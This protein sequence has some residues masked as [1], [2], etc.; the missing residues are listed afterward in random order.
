MELNT[1]N[2]FIIDTETTGMSSVYNRIIEIAILRVENGRVVE[3]YHTLLN[4]QRSLPRFIEGITGITSE[5]LENAPEFNDI[6][7]K[8]REL[9]NDAIFV[10]HNSAFDYGFLKNEFKRCGEGFYMKQLCTVKLSR[11]LYPKAQRHDLSSIIAR[12]NLTCLSRHRAYDDAKAL[13]DFI[14][15]A[16]IDL[17][18]EAVNTTAK[19]LLKMGH[20]PSQLSQELIDSLYDGPGVYIFRDGKDKE[21]YIGK[22]IH[23]KDRVLSHFQDVYKS[24]HKRELLQLTKTIESGRRSYTKNFIGLYAV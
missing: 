16:Q 22:S 3:T 5:D 10:A 4:P 11:L 15:A 19:K 2:L 6:K 12:H 13:W 1:N 20:R 24:G 17:G 23:I 8:I 18:H 14:L 7:D 9:S 21:L